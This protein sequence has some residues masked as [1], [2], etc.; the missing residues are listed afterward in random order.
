MKRNK[1]FKHPCIITVITKTFFEGGRGSRSSLAEKH[2]KHFS[3]VF[4]EGAHKDELELP[5]PIVAL[6]AAAV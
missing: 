4:E 3:S 1:P 2:S 5:I 6:A